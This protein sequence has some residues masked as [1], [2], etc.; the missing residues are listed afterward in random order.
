MI[1]YFIHCSSIL[2]IFIMQICFTI[3]KRFTFY[4]ILYFLQVA[5]PDAITKETSTPNPHSNDDHTYT[6]QKDQYH[7][8]SNRSQ[9]M[10]FATVSLV[11]LAAF[12][13]IIS[14]RTKSTMR[15]RLYTNN[16]D[17]TMT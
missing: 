6:N 11:V 17:C 5:G 10:Y 16:T 12:V 1:A 2:K 15:R 3:S 7:E 4:K 9:Y 13:C 14:V 8:D